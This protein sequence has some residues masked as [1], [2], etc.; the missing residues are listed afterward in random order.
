MPYCVVGLF[1]ISINFSNPIPLML[2]N[3]W[4][5]WITIRKSY[6][7]DRI[8]HIFTSSLNVT[9]Y[10]QPHTDAECRMFSSTS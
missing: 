3:T 4:F 10:G 5:E 7:I 8:F 9:S 6:N 1:Q 2:E